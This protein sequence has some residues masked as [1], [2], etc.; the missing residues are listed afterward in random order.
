MYKRQVIALAF[1]TLGFWLTAAATDNATTAFTAAVSV[2]IIACPCAL[3]LATPTAL[4]V[5]TGR[6][7]Q[8]GIL[9]KGPEVLE[10]TRKVD[11][12]VLDKTGTITSG[13]MSLVDVVTT[14]S[15]TAEEA[16]RLAGPAVADV[17]GGIAGVAAVVEAD[18]LRA[19]PRDDRRSELVRLKRVIVHRRAGPEGRGDGQ[20][21]RHVCIGV[22][23]HGETRSTSPDMFKI[24]HWIIECHTVAPEAHLFTVAHMCEAVSLI[25]LRSVCEMMSRSA[26]RATRS[27]PARTGR[28]ASLSTGGWV[29]PP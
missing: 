28:P 19:G 26:R 7:A 1:A 2:L 24:F 10:S 6:G 27:P 17:L 23:S 3:G 15:T 8:M 9:I 22:D 29:D 13:R 25:K 4:M 16:L 5:G 21:E 18:G 20:H 11:T 12:I 14:G